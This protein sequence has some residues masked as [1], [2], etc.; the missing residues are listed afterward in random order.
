MTND[1]DDTREVRRVRIADL[2]L[3]QQNANEGTQR[4]DYMLEHSLEEYGAGRSIVLDKDLNVIAGNKTLQKWAEMGAEEVVIVPND[5][6]KTLVAVY[7]DDLDLYAD[8]D[9]RGRLLAYADNVVSKTNLKLDASQIVGD[10][11]GGLDLSPMFF[12]EELS[13]FAQE[14]E[15]NP[16]FLDM[17]GFSQVG[18]DNIS[19]RVIVDNLSREEASELASEL[20]SARIEQYRA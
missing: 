6:G 19:Y 11:A 3:D 18:G 13:E 20:G 4:G 1:S 8:D 2:K 15:A 17:D 10:V 7:R 12:D 9:K 14:V 16:D 5:G